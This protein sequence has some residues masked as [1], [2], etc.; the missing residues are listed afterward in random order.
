V[1]AERATNELRLVARIAEVSALRRTPAGIPVVSCVLAHASRQIEAG[2]EREVKLELPA[3]AIGELA[4]TLSAV[5]PGAR[6]SVTG[7][8][9]A[10]SARSCSPVLHL[11]TIEFME[12]I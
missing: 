9:A 2:I 7:F 1:C 8:M 6:I 3:M 12:G 11:N 5:A 4:Q 10:K